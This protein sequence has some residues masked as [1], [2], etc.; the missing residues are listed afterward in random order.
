MLVYDGQDAAKGLRCTACTICET[1][2]P[3]KCIYIVKDTVK[4]PDYLGK[5]Q[6]QPKIFD[7]DISVC[8][9]CGICVEVCPFESIK[10]DQVF[11]LAGPDRFG[12][13][14]LHKDQL[15]KPNSYFNKIA[16]V[17]ASQIDANRA[18]DLRK[19][20]A[21]A[22][23]DAEAKAKAAAAATANATAGV[24]AAAAA[25]AASTAAKPA[26][27]TAKP[28]STPKPATPPATKPAP[29]ADKP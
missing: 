3:P 24:A 5:M 29:P 10:M 13:F 22:K 12:P 1:E 16:P 9:G 18:E 2:C 21:K 11:E 17:Q 26:P 14:L 19:A 23:A 7:I 15:A 20:E 27:A 25:T 8:M 6:N 4:K 28:L